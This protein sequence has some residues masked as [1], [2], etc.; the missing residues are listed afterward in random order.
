MDPAPS[1]GEGVPE[2]IVA[3]D[4][5][6]YS[7][8]Q[9]MGVP[10]S[11]TTIKVYC[12]LEWLCLELVRELA[13]NAATLACLMEG[14]AAWEEWNG[15]EERIMPPRSEKEEKYL[16]QRLREIDMELA[17]EEKRAAKKKIKA[18][19]NARKRMGVGKDQPSILK[20]LARKSSS[21]ALG[22]GLTCSSRSGWKS[23]QGAAASV[24]SGEAL[25]PEDE[26][27]ASQKCQGDSMKCQEDDASLESSNKPASE[28]ESSVNTHTGSVSLPHSQIQSAC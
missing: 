15:G 20:S 16:W 1:W 21:S 28:G 4:T 13:N 25:Q 8:N 9:E 7:S 23:S 10:T 24:V 12:G 17:R 11:Q 2:G 5:F 18:V 19:A 27:D 14:V 22:K 26:G 6:L 3:R